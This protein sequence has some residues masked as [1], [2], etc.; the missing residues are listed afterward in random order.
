MHIYVDADACPNVIKEILYRAA[1]RIK[2]PL[3]LV[4]NR[5]LN[6]PR[7]NY[8]KVIQV[9]GGM[10][11]AD[12]KIVE[13]VQ[14]GDLV[15]T[16]DIPLADHVVKKDA[17]ALDPRGKLYTTSNIRQALSIRN[18][19]TELRSGGVDTGGPASFNQ[20]DKQAFAD[21]LN[22]FLCKYGPAA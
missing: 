4:A 5:P 22:R 1:R 17:Y 19:M 7:S 11:V 9:P 15:I 8:I 16:A 6:V 14:S 2:I 21:Q 13:M 18:F 10:D 3:T 20:K 12:E